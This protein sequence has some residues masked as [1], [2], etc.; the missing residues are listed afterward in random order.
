MSGSPA[1]RMRRR[2]IPPL[3]VFT[4][5]RTRSAKGAE[6]GPKGRYV[7]RETALMFPIVIRPGRE[8]GFQKVDD[9]LGIA[10]HGHDDKVYLIRFH[11][12]P[13]GAWIRRPPGLDSVADNNQQRILAVPVLLCPF[14]GLLCRTKPTSIFAAG[15]NRDP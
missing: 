15:A 9:L 3:Y 1:A 7:D 2:F 13:S 8:S 6:R 4:L 10:R 5:S 12:L 11:Y 14:A